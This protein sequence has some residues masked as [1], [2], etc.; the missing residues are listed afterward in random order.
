MRSV[1]DISTALP[2]YLH[3]L[4]TI[5]SDSTHFISGSLFCPL[6][7]EM[8]EASR[9]RAERRECA[10]ATGV[11]KP[12][13]RCPRDEN[14][15]L[16]SWDGERGCWVDGSEQQHSVQHNVKQKALRAAKAMERDQARA[17]RAQQSVEQR[18]QRAEERVLQAYERACE[19]DHQWQVK[20]V[21]DLII[22][23]IAREEKRER[24]VRERARRWLERRAREEA[25]AVRCEGMTKQGVRCRVY[26]CYPGDYAEPLRSGSRYC[27]HHSA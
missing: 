26:S 22:Q 14:G 11:S 10:R 8:K 1:S 16:C 23:Q 21:L 5:T 25:N 27:M 19:R 18:R 17:Q 3:L 4:Y 15:L 13:G 20:R 6:S 12:R 9:R 2:V 7:H 24:Q